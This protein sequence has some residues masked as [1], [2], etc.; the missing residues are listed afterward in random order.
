MREEHRANKGRCWLAGS[1]AKLEVC[2]E[3]I[4]PD[5]EAL[6]TFLQSN[7][8]S[9]YFPSAPLDCM[10]KAPSVNTGG[11]INHPRDGGWQKGESERDEPGT[12]NSGKSVMCRRATA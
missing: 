3:R 12:L 6:E 8:L 9:C 2:D 4:V 10:G 5:Q 1:R 7:M 11:Y